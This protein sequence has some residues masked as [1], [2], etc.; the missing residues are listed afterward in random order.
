M[1][2]YH[3]HTLDTHGHTH[4]HAP[5]RCYWRAHLVASC[6]DLAAS[7]PAARATP[8][9]SSRC[10]HSRYCGGTW[11]TLGPAVGATP[12]CARVARTQPCIAYITASSGPCRFPGSHPHWVQIGLAQATAC[13]PHPHHIQGVLWY[14]TLS[15]F[16][17]HFAPPKHPRYRTAQQGIKVSRYQTQTQQRNEGPRYRGMPHVDAPVPVPGCPP[18]L[19][20]GR[21]YTPSDTSSSVPALLTAVCGWGPTPARSAALEAT[22][23]PLFSGLVLP[24]SF[25]TLE[26]SFF[27]SPEIAPLPR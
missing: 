23:T 14:D 8:G 11:P 1:L 3:T 6:A 2:C 15:L 19:R 16:S 9:T 26:T 17:S 10:W 25:A 12:T 18:S 27:W 5:H 7:D 13:W 20:P 22:P 21:R 4:T 24:H